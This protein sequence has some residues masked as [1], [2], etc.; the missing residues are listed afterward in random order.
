MKG[1]SLGRKVDV[2]YKSNL[3]LLIV[4]AL[5]VV[6]AWLLSGSVFRGLG[7]GGGFFLCWALTRE[8]DPVH[9]ISAFVAGGIFLLFPTLYDGIDFGILFWLLLLMRLISRICGKNPS[10]ID[11]LSMFGLTG[12][13][14][15]ARQN[16]TYF[17]LL[18]IALVLAFMR[19]GKDSP[20]GL[21]AVLGAGLSLFCALFLPPGPGSLFLLE[22]RAA[23]PVFLMPIALGTHISWALEK[24]RDIKDDLGEPL[25]TRWIRLSNFFYVIVVLML[26]LFENISLSSCILLFSVMT[27]VTAFRIFQAIMGKDQR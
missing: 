6:L 3:W 23:I 16:S 14:T 22:R 4:P 11:L 24:D 1:F 18:T 5:V 20:L 2:R 19:N 27:G 21:S 10:V 25:E 7:L 13:L 9:E 8:V 15:Y 26:L 12:Y 17:F